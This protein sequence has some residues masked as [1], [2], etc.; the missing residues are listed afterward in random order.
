MHPAPIRAG[1]N[2]GY[3]SYE[4]VPMTLAPFTTAFLAAF[5]VA[6]FYAQPLGA[7]EQ[8]QALLA[9]TER[10][11]DAL[12]ETLNG[13][14]HVLVIDNPAR[15]TSSRHVELQL[16]DGTLVPLRGDGTDTLHVGA[17]A[18]VSGKQNGE[19]LEVASAREVAGTPNASGT[20]VDTQI[21]G[22]FAIL[23]ADDFAAG[24]SL[25]IYELHQASGKVSRLRLGSL[26]AAL[27]PGM[28]LRVAGHA[29]ADGESVTPDHITI[30]AEPTS[31]TYETGA[32]AKAATAHNVLVITANFS[33]TAVPAFT[34]AQ[35][36]QVMTSNADSVANFFRETSYGQQVMNVTVTPSW[37]TMALAE[38]ATCGSADWQNI[39]MS[40][41]AAAKALG[42]SYDPAAYEF[43][44]YLFP[45]VSACGWIGW[46]YIGS[47]R[48]AW[49]NGTASF[50]TLT[51]AHEMGHN[52]G[53]LHAASLRCGSNVVGGSCAA[54]EYGDAFDTMGNQRSMHYNVVQKSKLG[55]IAST[56][57]KTY[58][59]GAV[60]YT[61]SPLEI[62]GGTTYA[63]KI[64]TGSTKR[65]YWIEYRQPIGFDSPLSAYPNNGAQIRV[66]SPF[67]TLCSGCGSYSDDTE[68][69]DTTPATSAFTDATLTVGRTFSDPDYSINVTVLAA[70]ASALTVQV[71]TGATVPPAPS[72]TATMVKSS[73]NPAMAGSSVT[74]TATVTGSTPTGTV[75]FT[76]DGASIAGC[77]AA[78]VSASTLGTATCGT[79]ALTAG[80]HAIV[81]RYSGDAAN[82]ASSSTTLSQVMTA[83]INGTNVALLSNGGSASASSVWGPSFPAWTVIDGR[84]SGANWGNYAGWADGTRGSY[85]DWVQVNF[86]GT[87]SIDHVVV[88]SVQDNFLAPVE[89]TDTMTGT[90]F[91]LMS[92]DVQGWN[93]SAW[94]TLATVRNNNLIK[95][96]V[97]FATYSTDRVRVVVN[98]T[99]DGNWSRMTELEAWSPTATVSFDYALSSNG[100]T[101]SASSI[102]G[103]SFPAWTV[104]D[105]RRSGANW[106][107]DAGWADG[108]SGA[109]PDWVQV[110]FNGPRAIDHVV[111]YSVQDD[112]LNPV[113]PTDAMTGTRF[114]LSS[115][116]VQA[117]NG[118]SWITLATVS[119]NNLI[120]R[121]VW[122]PAYATSRLRIDVMGTQ[123]GK[124]SR[125]TEI[126]AWGQ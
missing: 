125:V 113:E 28:R 58:T 51:I 45:K 9:Q 43:V 109:F 40:A 118:S 55:W 64:P 85:P 121:T 116:D 20:K 112:F 37:V 95:R 1:P 63:I 84:R 30:L 26:P 41:E 66:S 2:N 108:T 92:F 103:L 15:G 38:P 93:G 48:K 17:R 25:F 33:N 50:R 13:V 62:A 22:A 46:G 104:I 42:G 34:A 105:N 3:T 67:E 56:S 57:V 23:H 96:T 61:L 123:D 107:N 83:P 98:G 99:P 18:S 87:K 71:A 7:H 54:S 70:S 124:W 81:A 111:V 72:Q 120:K 31:S 80:T 4:R 11:A 47:P 90:Q 21:E 6:L 82:A 19:W 65:I 5:S 74:F 8:A 91:V 102:W 44:V 77:A 39:G 117:W 100:A 75:Q 10:D 59:G 73:V 97:S 52:F 126:E 122:F 86:N 68:L 110:N 89:P 14:V 101:A 114:V 16:D 88:Y 94:V 29:E 53:L 106:G 115:F 27:A 76:A 119:G 69:L 35:A 79:N 49:I 24:K 32:T 60:T 12:P 78:A 36:Q